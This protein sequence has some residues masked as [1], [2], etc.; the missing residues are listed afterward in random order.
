MRTSTLCVILT[1]LTMPGTRARALSREAESQSVATDYLEMAGL[2]IETLQGW[3]VWGTGL[4]TTAGWWNSANALTALVNYSIA[5]VSG[6]YLPVVL[7]TYNRHVSGG[8]LNNYYDDEGWWALAWI[9][10]YDWTGDATYLNTANAIFDD[11]TTGWDDAC[12][13][14]VWWS[15]SRTYKNAI[16]NE[17]FLSVAAHLANRETDPD[18]QAQ[19]FAWAEAEWQWFSQ[20]G[21]INSLNL[22]N[23]GL[24]SACE[25]NNG[26][27]WTYNQG[28]ILGG[29]V[30]LSQ[31]DPDPSLPDTAQ[32]I[33]TA[34][35]DDL[36]DENGI[37]HDRCEPSCGA[38][39]VQFKG[40]FLRNLMALDGSFPDTLYQTFA[41]TNAQSI[42]NDAQGPNYQFGLVWSGPFDVGDA[43][44]Q[45]SALDAIIAA[46]EMQPCTFC[47]SRH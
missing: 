26:T 32:A 14:G 9:A 45:S 33:A 38:D 16:A 15:K 30:E 41:E 29:L 17:L 37:L 24:N 23:D 43:A 2:G 21:M 1:L 28:V 5:S 34:T 10:A 4:W 40:I 7:N 42:W 18:R 47:L 8:F 25:N 39:G 12:G 11:M 31:Q 22:I 13:G 36:T 3:Y 44:R 19:D 35:I 20:S 27:T 6:S 46:A